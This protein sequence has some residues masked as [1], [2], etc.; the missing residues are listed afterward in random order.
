MVAGT[1][2]YRSSLP[3]SVYRLIRKLEG[4]PGTA[5]GEVYEMEA[6]GLVGRKPQGGGSDR[7]LRPDEVNRL[8][9]QPLVLQTRIWLFPALGGQMGTR[10]VLRNVILPPEFR[11]LVAQYLL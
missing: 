2:L 5:G 4:R 7:S 1:Y 3:D 9:H 8:G 6:K 10:W 11:I